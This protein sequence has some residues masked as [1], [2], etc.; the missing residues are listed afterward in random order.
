MQ[1]LNK[2]IDTIATVRFLNCLRGIGKT[3][4]MLENITSCIDEILL[5]K[6][7][8]EILVI[9]VNREQKLYLQKCLANRYLKYIEFITMQ[10]LMYKLSEFPINTDD[11]YDIP[12]IQLLQQHYAIGENK[13]IRQYERFFVDPSCYEILYRQQLDKIKQVK[14]ILG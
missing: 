9:C 1:H 6:S 10:S 12:N 7:E 8:F 11:P 4:G 2:Q 3:K 14:E 13:E 5:Y